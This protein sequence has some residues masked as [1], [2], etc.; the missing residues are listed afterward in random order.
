MLS[1]RFVV[2]VLLIGSFSFLGT[3]LAQA[4]AAPSNVA[5]SAHPDA[6]PQPDVAGPGAYSI[7]FDSGP[8]PI[9]GTYHVLIGQECQ[10]KINLPPVVANATVS[11]Q[12]TISGNTVQ[13]KSWSFGSGNTSATFSGLVN[14]FTSSSQAVTPAMPADAVWYWDDKT[15]SQTVTCAVTIT[16]PTGAGTPT[17]KTVMQQVTLDVPTFVPNPSVGAV[18]LDS[19]YLAY[20]NQVALHAGADSNAVPGITFNDSVTIPNSTLYSSKYGGTGSWYRVQLVSVNRT[21]YALNTGVASTAPGNSVPNALDYTTL[22]NG[23]TG[24]VYNNQFILAD[25]SSYNSQKNSMAENDSPGFLVFDT[26]Q[27]YKVSNEKYTDYIMYTAP[28]TSIDVPLASCSWS[29]NADVHIP[30][31]PLPKSWA[32]YGSTPTGGTITPYSSA[33]SQLNYPV[34]TALNQQNLP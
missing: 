30:Q 18:E 29:W 20:P 6:S 22:A 34:W 2:P 26:Y 28:G 27:E 3:S 9:N 7:S 12:W 16:P 4:Q 8:I 21:E 31:T 1:L 5:S 32:N 25:G 11:C 14:P 10:A 24:I 19:N 13:A 17:S 15:A 33:T 23:G